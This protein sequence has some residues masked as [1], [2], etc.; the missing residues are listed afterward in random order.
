[1]PPMSK[2]GCQWPVPSVT[3]GPSVRGRRVCVLVIVVGGEVVVRGMMVVVRLGWGG[4]EARAGSARRMVGRR[5]V[6]CMEC[7]CGCR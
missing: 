5:V 7:G 6:A 4:A 3:M 1:M 2:G